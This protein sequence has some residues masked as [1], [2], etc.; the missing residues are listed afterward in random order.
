MPS[1]IYFPTIDPAAEESDLQ[2]EGWSTINVP[3]ATYPSCAS[4]FANPTSG[5]DSFMSSIQAA[6][7]NTVI[8]APTCAV[9]YN[10]V[11]TFQFNADFVLEVQSFTTQNTTVFESTNGTARN[12]S[13]LA[14]ADA[15]CSNTVDVSFSNLTNFVA[16]ATGSNPNGVNMFIY[17][18]GAV[19]YANNPTMTGQIMACGNITGSNAFS[20]TYSNTASKELIGIGQAG[21]PTITPEDKYVC[22]YVRNA[23]STN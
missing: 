2:A 7:N 8:Y 12:V 9:S 16:P 1:S 14:S 19:S 11:V 17:T 20:M 10:H 18:E 15:T 5:N 4:F 6:T 21:S 23:C 3:S 13:I 22:A